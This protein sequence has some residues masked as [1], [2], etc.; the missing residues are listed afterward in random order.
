MSAHGSTM[1]TCF[2]WITMTALSAR[3]HSAPFQLRDRSC[4]SVSSDAMARQSPVPFVSHEGLEFVPGPTKH[5]E[6]NRTVNPATCAGVV[7]LPYHPLAR[8]E[9][10]RPKQAS[11]PE[12]L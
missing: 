8:S 4:P 9:R 10:G 11:Q 2:L 5:V 6:I 7:K 12:P 1:L 3:S